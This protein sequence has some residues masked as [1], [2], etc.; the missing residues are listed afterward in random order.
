MGLRVSVGGCAAIPAWPLVVAL[1]VIALAAGQ[2]VGPVL[3][4]S[5]TGQTSVTVSLGLTLDIDYDMDQNPRFETTP[6]R[7]PDDSV[8][9]RSPDGS[10]FTVSGELHTGETAALDVFLENSAE[11]DAGAI[12]EVTVPSGVEVDIEELGGSG[13]DFQ[14]A[15]LDRTRWLFWVDGGAGTN[16][17]SATPLL[18]DDGFALIIRPQADLNPGFYNI[19]VVITQVIG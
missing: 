2:A 4:G 16:E 5:A 12:V 10:Q 1:G 15:Q 19:S 7:N 6:G 9:V 14:A 11:A 18:G 13:D 3:S 8:A 17:N